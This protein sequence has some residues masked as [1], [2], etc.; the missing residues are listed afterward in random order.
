MK[1]VTKMVEYHLERLAR[2]AH[3]EEEKTLQITSRLPASLKIRLDTCAEFL[4][5][6]RNSFLQE[7]L[8][9]A[10]PAAEQ[11]LRD[12]SLTQEQIGPGGHWGPFSYDQAVEA[13]VA[14]FHRTGKQT[15]T[16]GDLEAI[17]K[18]ASIEFEANGEVSDE[19]ND[20][21]RDAGMP[22]RFLK[23]GEE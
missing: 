16:M 21:L 13:F 22:V 14:D 23:E 18:Q 20:A 8:E 12:A 6:T 3:H 10:L 19:T 5:M 15:A 1:Q 17:L 2:Q 11:A 4:G 9:A 7:L